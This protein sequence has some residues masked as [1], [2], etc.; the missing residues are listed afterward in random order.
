MTLLNDIKKAVKD[1]SP[2]N[3]LVTKIVCSSDLENM[4]RQLEK[5]I[6]N[7]FPGL[8]FGVQVEVD[9]EM[10]PESFIGLNNYGKVVKVAIK[11]GSETEVFKHIMEKYNA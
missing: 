6:G 1:L 9:L 10:P 11:Q 8:D 3:D 7:P 2:D 4:I 5:K